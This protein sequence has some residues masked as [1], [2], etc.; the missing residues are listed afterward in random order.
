MY[1]ITRE[2]SFEK[3]QFWLNELQKNTDERPLIVL[4]GNKV[5]LDNLRS[6]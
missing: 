3:A 2:D 5:D 6:S 4:A 1:D